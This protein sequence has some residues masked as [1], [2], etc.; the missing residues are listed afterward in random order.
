MAGEEVTDI[1]SMHFSEIPRTRRRDWLEQSFHFWCECEACSED[2]NT[3]DL[4]GEKES[5]YLLFHLVKF[6]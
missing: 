2:W 1:Y 4:L 6:N 5:V 3:F